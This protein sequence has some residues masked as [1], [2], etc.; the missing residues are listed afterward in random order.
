MNQILYTIENEEEK[1]RT[2]S[3][4]LFFAITI[5]IFGIVMLAMGGYQIATAKAAREEAIEAAKIPNIE[6]EFAEESNNVIIRVSH[7][8]AIKDITYS[9]NNEEEIVLDENS[10]TDVEEYI[11]LPAG[12]NTLN[13]TVTDIEG[14]TVAV[15]EE[16]TYKGTYMEVSVID[17]KS[18]RIVVTDMVGLQSVAY[19]WNDEEEIVSYPDGEDLTVIEVTSDIPIGQNTITVRAVNNENNIEEKQ[20]TVQGISRPTIGINYNSDKTLISIRLN[21]DQGIQSYSYKLSGAPISE[22]AENGSIIPEFKDKLTVIT[23]QTKEGQGQNSI[24]EQVEF[25]EGFNYLE[26]TIINIEGVEETYSGWCAK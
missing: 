23:S 18:L 25:M 15:S 7:V 5:M 3:I 1:N 14:K 20:V 4:I 11:E 17:N 6:L 19:K 21:D 16:F 2:K 12:T 9:W 24:L 10:A 13:V 22:I 8:R 26:I